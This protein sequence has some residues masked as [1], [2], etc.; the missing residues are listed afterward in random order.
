MI[1]LGRIDPNYEDSVKDSEEKKKQYDD[2]MKSNKDGLKTIDDLNKLENTGEKI[3]SPE[4]KKM[5]L[6]ESLFED[7]FDDQDDG[8]SDDDLVQR[9]CDILNGGFTTI[10]NQA[11]EIIDL[12]RYWDQGKDDPFLESYQLDE[13]AIGSLIDDINQDIV[14]NV[15]VGLEE[16]LNDSDEE[17]L[18]GL[19]YDWGVDYDPYDTGANSPEELALQLQTPEDFKQAYDFIKEAMEEGFTDDEGFISSTNDLLHKLEEYLSAHGIQV[20]AIT[21]T[22]GLKKKTLTEALTQSEVN[23]ICNKILNEYPGKLD[24]Y[25][26][27]VDDKPYATIDFIIENGDWK[28]DHLAFRYWMDQHAEEITDCT[29]KFGGENTIDDSQDDTYSATHTYYFIPK[30][31]EPAE[32]PEDLDTEHGDE[33]SEDAGDKVVY[34]YDGD[35]IDPSVDPDEEPF[36]E[37]LKFKIAKEQI[38]R[39]NEGKMSSNWDPKKYLSSLV[40]HRHITQEESKIL[41]ETFLK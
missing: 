1:V 11:R 7:L 2:A 20:D 26:S 39:Y 10:P 31:E 30:D 6:S 41:V 28:H 18:I 35:E 38:K 3:S 29:V 21:V 27:F 19:L 4:L 15:D 5:H 17:E 37:S 33:S 23:D 40:E 8:Q 13:D 24:V 34:N 14:G 12:V 32:E 16:S 9:V 36:S 22:E 25:H